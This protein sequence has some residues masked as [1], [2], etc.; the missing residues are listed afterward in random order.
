MRRLKYYCVVFALIMALQVGAAEEFTVKVLDKPDTAKKRNEIYAG[1][2]E[3][4]LPSPLS[5]LPFGAVKPRG[6][7][8]KQLEL[9]A[10]GFTGHLTEISPWCKKEGNAWLNPEGLGHS[11]WEEVAYWLRGYAALGY[12]LDD[13]TIIREAQPWIDNLFAGQTEYGY[14]GPNYSLLAPI[15]PPVPAEVLTTPDG[16]PGLT[17]EYFSD[18]EFKNSVGTRVDP[19]VDFMWARQRPPMD[20]MDGERYSIRWT[21][22]IT[23]KKSDDYVFSLFSDDGARL[24]IDGNM[25]VENWGQHG[26]FTVTAKEPVRLEAG[27]PYQLKLEYYQS[28]NNAE[29]RLGWKQPGCTYMPGFSM[30]D[31]MPNMNMLFVLRSYYEYTGDKRVIDLMTKY[32]KWQL[33]VPDDL[34]FAGGWQ[35]A[36]TGDNIDSIYWL[37]N[38][39]GEP[40]LLDL[41]AKTER[42]GSRWLTKQTGGHNVQFSQGFRKPALFYQQSKDPEYLKI[43]EGN[44]DSMM[45]IYGQA[46]GGTFGGDEFA[47]PGRTD[48]RQAI[49]TCGCVE[50]AISEELLLRITGEAKWADR[51]ENAV[52]NTL[53]ATMTPDMKALRYLTSPNQVNSDHRSKAPG[54]CNGGPQQLMNPFDHRCCLH[55]SGS[56]WPYFARSLWHAV[57]GSGLSA[58]FYADCSV[59]AK[60]GKGVI[61][62]IEEDT[63]YPFDGKVEFKIDPEKNVKFPLYLRIPGWCR[64]AS[65]TLNGRALEVESKPG[66][67]LL[68][69]R[70][71][72]KGD[73]LTLDLSMEVTLTTWTANKNSVSVD[74]GPL[75]FSVK[76]GENYVRFEPER[77]PDPWPVWEIVPTTQWNY[78]LDF[79]PAKLSESF[80][81]VE[82]PWPSNNMTFTHEGT[83]VEIQARARKLPNWQEDFLGLVDSLQPSPVKSSEPV[84]TITMIPMG[85]ARLRLTAL[86]VIGSGTDAR[87]WQLPPGPL[88]SYMRDYES[89]DTMFDG[90]VPNRSS[91]RRGGHFTTYGEG[92]G[93]MQ[94]VR[95]NLDAETTVSSCELFWYDETDPP[96]EVRL[97]KSWR[98]LYLVGEEWKEVENPSGYGIES[99]IYNV[100][101]FTPVKTT[102]LRLEVQCQDTPNRY[103]MGI[104]EW[105]IK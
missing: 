30:P 68:L 59:Q 86:P 71:W 31:L 99:D 4:L 6:W 21:G 96:G 58:T 17:G 88:A 56:A 32:F 29:I 46:P 42:S 72:Q 54:L 95:R 41:A 69:D 14:F 81:V 2:R 13:E 73:R 70:T 36:R 50:M 98:V 25:I 57:P 37:Y 67:Y 34:F 79:D 66:A 62:N 24:W 53:P 52:L 47:R 10:D 75:T 76:I 83:P 38:R 55:N 7:L 20:G 65:V 63:K 28:I 78:A 22:L 102:A 97:P 27:K 48:P 9:E 103:A 61:V 64:K 101:T 105:A 5:S 19:K 18:E 104:C 15:H 1:N 90:K 60:V 45:G 80:K 43:T 89:Y 77:F 51:C 100:V 26:A 85:A 91:S 39:T 94:W 49:E 23:V 84:E 12:I 82:K 11:G 16:K 33:S 87:E 3:P 8:R 44:W 35:T 93:E 74:R 92:H 40:F